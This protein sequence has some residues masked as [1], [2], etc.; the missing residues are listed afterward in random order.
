MGQW[1]KEVAS[2]R[3]DDKKYEEN[4]SKI[5][6]SSVQ[7]YECKS[8]KKVIKYDDLVGGKCGDCYLEEGDEDYESQNWLRR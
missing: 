2:L 7:V 5:D 3:G 8:C 4:F 1:F 6:W